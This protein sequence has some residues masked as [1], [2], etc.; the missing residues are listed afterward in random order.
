MK[1]KI[2]EAAIIVCVIAAF[3]LE[4]GFGKGSG[5]FSYRDDGTVNLSEG[6]TAYGFYLP[7]VTGFANGDDPD[8]DKLFESRRAYAYHAVLNEKSEGG[9]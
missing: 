8:W 3:L 9:R 4:S 2:S 7:D 6:Y 1:R 5:G